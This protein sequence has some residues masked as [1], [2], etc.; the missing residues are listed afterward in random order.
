METNVVWKGG[1]AFEAELDGHKFMIDAEQAV[2]GRNLGPRPKGL[3]VTALVGC[4]GMDV[5]S[6]LQKMRVPLSRLEVKAVGD[7]TDDHPR[8]FHTIT[9]QYLFEGVD[10]PIDRLKRAVELSETRYCGVSATLAPTVT[11]KSEIWVNGEQVV[12]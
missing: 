6:I 9:V 10:L 12:D 8:K 3:L 5:A 2:G 1:L 4:T 7:L 11:L